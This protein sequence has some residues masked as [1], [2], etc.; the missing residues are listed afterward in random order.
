MSIEGREATLV[1]A[2]ASAIAQWRRENPDGIIAAERAIVASLDLSGADLSGANLAGGRFTRCDLSHV[3]FAE[4]NLQAVVFDDCVLEDV[5]FRGANL[6]ATRINAIKLDGARFGGSRSL[7]R[8]ARLHV[9]DRVLRPIAV[10][11]KALA[12]YDCWVGWDRLRFLATIRIFIPAYTS[13]TLTVFYLNGVAYYN[14]LVAILDAQIS[15]ISGQAG[16]P[17]LPSV[18]PAWTDTLVLANFAFLALAATCFLGCP[19][20]VVEFSRER[21]LNEFQQPEILYDHATWQRPLIRLLC[22]GTLLVGGLLSVFLLGRGIFQ[23]TTFVIRH[24]VG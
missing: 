19:A 23:Q 10:D 22:A 12:W 14:S 20:R 18:A 17:L 13:L 21:W 15:R 3:S 11:R 6:K 24:I 7:G 5:E 1:R 2:G 16:I 4:S 9:I 8:L